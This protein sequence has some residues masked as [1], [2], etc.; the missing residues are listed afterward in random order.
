MNTQ[1]KKL[2]ISAVLSAAL[3]IIGA[4]LLAFGGAYEFD[5]PFGYF[6]TGSL[7]SVC[8][9]AVLALGVILG[10][11]LWISERKTAAGAR[12]LPSC[13]AVPVISAVCGAAV[14]LSTVYD[15]LDKA[16]RQPEQYA[17]VTYISWIFSII[18][19]ISLF[20]TAFSGKKEPTA[21][22]CLLSFFPPLYFASLVLT[23]YFDRSVAVNS[24]VKVIIQITFIA[25]MLM[26]TAEAGINLGRAKVYPRYLFTLC[27]AT[28]LG[29]AAGIG[30]LVLH[31][32][33][34]SF[35]ISL[36][37]SVLFTLFA[38][39]S[40]VRLFCTPAYY[41]V[42]AASV[43]EKESE[44]SAGEVMKEAIMESLEGQEEE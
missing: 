2:F 6:Q 10:L 33:K 32:C 5:A 1:N 16:G 12:L 30:G 19:A 29:G 3:G 13:G 31:F 9:Y 23:D 42:P 20:C 7:Y 17:A 26:L 8:L 25:F 18:A 44:K 36:M 37:D 22:P 39:Y 28:V 14:L 21:L 11:Y 24:P 38:L 15:F 35:P 4:L 40:A 41:T 27:A 34:I 43:S